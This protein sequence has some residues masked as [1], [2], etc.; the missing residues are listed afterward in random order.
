MIFSKKEK[1]I[2]AYTAEK[3]PSCKRES[4]R[5]FKQGDFLFAESSQCPSCNIPMNIAKIFGEPIE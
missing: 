2:V 4:K 3:C 5:K 1:Q